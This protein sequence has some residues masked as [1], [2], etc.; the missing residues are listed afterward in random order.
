M[1][2][3]SHNAVQQVF[4]DSYL[5][6]VLRQSLSEMISLGWLVGRLVFVTEVCLAAVQAMF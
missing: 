3:L 6:N 1:G 5:T 2:E 4:S